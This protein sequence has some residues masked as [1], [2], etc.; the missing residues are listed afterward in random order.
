M[1]SHLRRHSRLVLTDVLQLASHA[2]RCCPYFQLLFIW[3]SR[4]W[5][6]SISI[7]LS[8]I[9]AMASNIK[10]L[11]W[12]RGATFEV[13]GGYPRVC[14]LLRWRHNQILVRRCGRLHILCWRFV[15]L[16]LGRLALILSDVLRVGVWHFQVA[17]VSF[18]CAVLV[19]TDA[20]L[21]LIVLHSLAFW[22]LDG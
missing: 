19:E 14:Q 13:V 7:N 11:G 17:I 4:C 2:A 8:E 20:L 9:L 21:L 5:C 10:K 1:K 12:P 18:G 15:L 16:V 22:L 6:S 3:A